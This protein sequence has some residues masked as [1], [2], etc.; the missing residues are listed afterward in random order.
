MKHSWIFMLLTALAGT[1]L[2]S[3][4]PV[5]A[6]EGCEFN[7]EEEEPRPVY[8]PQSDNDP[9]P[10]PTNLS[11]RSTKAIVRIL[12]GASATC[13]QR[14]Q[15]RYRVDCLRLYYGWVADSLPERGDYAPIRQAMLDAEAK[16]DAI[17]RANLDEGAP[18]I[19]PRERH[20]PAAG[21][22]PPVRAIK[23]ERAERAAAEAAKVIEEVELVILR[24]GGDP[25][26]RTPHYTAIAAA[27]EDNLVIL[28]S[29]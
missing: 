23:E 1:V 9:S 28:R 25:A 21:R 20:K 11:D 22:V 29:A 19:R 26:R 10:V 24:S 13:D 14:I 12:E 18:A 4:G 15:L 27:V 6:Q 8:P 5:Q 7:C 17:V 3:A 2:L 16:L